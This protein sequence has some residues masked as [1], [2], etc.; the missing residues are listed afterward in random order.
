MQEW[1]TVSRQVVFELG[2]YLKVES[3]QLQLPD[4]NVIDNWPWLDTPDYAIVLAVR[5]DGRFLC[6]RQTK[7][8]VEDL[9]LAPVG[10][11][12]EPGEQ[13]LEAA[14]RELLE[15]TGYSAGQWVPLGSYTVDGN[16]GNGRAHLF[17]ALEAH[18]ESEPHADD[19]EEQ[20]LHFLTL[21]ELRAALQAGEFKVLA[22]TTAV[23][24]SLL[25][26]SRAADK[27]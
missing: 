2:P 3:R 18:Q 10:G 23:A 27:T 19:L 15:E 22:W 26:F 6:F 20:Q 1:K 5:A 24:L 11:Y 12:L 21:Q 14:R 4:G 8:A 7:Y 9:T 17:L 13:P 25:Y 16:H